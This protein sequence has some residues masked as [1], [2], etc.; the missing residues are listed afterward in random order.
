VVHKLREAMSKRDGEYILAGRLELDEGYFST[1]IHLSEK[2][3]ILKH[4]R[5]GLKKTKVI[6]MVERVLL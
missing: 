4:G 2:Y 3:K 1:E 6:V 5:G